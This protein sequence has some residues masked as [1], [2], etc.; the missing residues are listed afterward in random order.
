[1][2]MVSKCECV[3][4]FVWCRCITPRRPTPRHT[5]PCTGLHRTP[6]VYAFIPVWV[7]ILAITAC[8]QFVAEEFVDAIRKP[9]RPPGT[10]YTSATHTTHTRT[11]TW[12]RRAPFVVARTRILLGVQCGLLL[13]G[14]V[15]L[16]LR[17]DG[18]VQW[19]WGVVLG[20]IA[21]ALY[22]P[23]LTVGARTS[24]SSLW[25][26]VVLCVAVSYDMAYGL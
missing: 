1:M 6:Y 14:S 7:L 22:L 5:V 25:S 9:Q 17:L 10:S 12:E 19:R 26:S 13:V 11:R 20:L 15:A 16:A 3:C 24:A 2:L 21:L 8:A 18:H 23:G 4:V